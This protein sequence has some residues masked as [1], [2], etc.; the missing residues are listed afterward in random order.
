[1][2]VLNRVTSFGENTLCSIFL[3]HVTGRRKVGNPPGLGPGDRVFESRRPDL[4]NA[5]VAQL[6]EHCPEEAGVTGSNPVGRT[7]VAARFP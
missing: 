6:V 1:M 3:H 7:K 5:S 2:V 4:K